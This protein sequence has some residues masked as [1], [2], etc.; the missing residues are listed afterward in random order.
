MENIFISIFN[1]SINAAWLA[2]AVII[3]RL[4]LKNAPKNIRCILWALVGIRL[5]LPF[6]ISSIFSLIP[7]AQV[8]PPEALIS[9]DPKEVMP[10]LNELPSSAANSL[11]P[12]IG[13][14][15]NPLQILIFIAAN[16]WI[17]GIIIMLCSALVSYL[18]L[19]RMVQVS[20]NVRENI[21]LCDNID[22]PF[23]LGIFNPRIYIPSDTDIQ[24]TASIEAHERTHLKRLDHIWKPLGYA[25]LSLHWFN[26]L[27]WAAYSLF[28]RDIELACDERVIKEMNT[29]QKQEYSQALLS[30]SVSHDSVAACPLAFGEVGVKQRI[31][32]I[33]SYKKPAL[34]IIIVA[35]IICGIVAVC[36]LTNPVGA[37]GNS[38]MFYV[39]EGEIIDASPELEAYLHNIILEHHRGQYLSG[40]FAC[41]AHTTLEV[42]QNGSHTTAYMLVMY[43]EYSLKGGTIEHVSGGHIPTVITVDMEGSGYSLIEYWESSYG[44]LYAPSIRE[45]YPWYLADKAIR[46]HEY[47]D[48]HSDACIAQAEEHFG[49]EYADPR[50]DTVWTTTAVTVPSYV[51]SMEDIVKL[52]YIGAKAAVCGLERDVIIAA[53][54]K[55]S[56]RAENDDHWIFEISPEESY[57]VSVE[58]QREGDRYIACNAVIYDYVIDLDAGYGEE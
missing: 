27:M 52:D 17:F 8:I 51:I 6:S 36:F 34:W 55:P 37:E 15:V 40:G 9:P 53:W 25:L 58:Y 41:E 31:K 43:G 48:I 47:A 49:V 21:Y 46:I 26:P 23:I 24:Q 50:K 3:L 11:T 12:G 10:I 57:A 4:I 33:F 14:S 13:A 16:I 18:K 19:R 45:K 30:C 42:R 39:P 29:Q 5:V 20:I 1:M 56:G 38:G 7:N 22:S 2:A 32:S 44:T 35:V 28:C 54:G